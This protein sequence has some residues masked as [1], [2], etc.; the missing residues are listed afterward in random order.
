MKS[1]LSIIATITLFSS[2]ANAQYYEEYFNNTATPRTEQFYDGQFSRLNPTANN[3]PS[4]VATGYYQGAVAGVNAKDRIRVVR[5]D[6]GGTPI[7]NNAYKVLI[8]N[9]EVNSYGYSVAETGGKYVAA[10][11]VKDA[12][13]TAG[14]ADILIMQIN[15]NNGSLAVQPL[16]VDMDKLQD[17]P[18]CIIASA[19][20]N[21]YYICGENFNATGVNP[22]SF[23]LKYDAVANAVVWVR[24][25]DHSTAAASIPSSLYSLCELTTGDIVACGKLQVNAGDTDGLITKVNAAGGAI[26]HQS[27]NKYIY[28]EFRSIKKS[29]GPKGP[30]VLTGN[31]KIN[32][33]DPSSV[34]LL[35]MSATWTI[36]GLTLSTP[37]DTDYSY[38]VAERK[39][40]TGQYEYF[41]SGKTKTTGI[42][43]NYQGSVFKY[44]ATTNALTNYLYGETRD[45]NFYAID[46]FNIGGINDGM[47]LFGQ[48]FKNANFNSWIT[49]AYLNGLTA[50]GC[51][52]VSPTTS[53]VAIDFVTTAKQP[54]TKTTYTQLKI[55]AGA[56]AHQHWFICSGANP[57]GSNA[58]VSNNGGDTKINATNSIEGW[59]VYP[60]P[61]GEN[62]ELNIVF[63]LKQAN[64]V[65]IELYDA[66]GRLLS[67]NS[68]EA[69]NGNNQTT[70]DM[71]SY[72]KGSY[73]LRLISQDVN[74]IHK[75][76]K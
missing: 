69:Y 74:L 27:Y 3:V 53:K 23:I 19:T 42:G 61:M 22:T 7:F 62:G 15:A 44:N 5:T 14:G 6:I 49:K 38:D 25:F 40:T 66:T 35:W 30:F 10:G 54:Q 76:I 64:N 2:V 72:P 63:D 16:K 13:L 67:S 57:V 20:A 34:L 12:N 58:L 36:G 65:H 47:A 48:I 46:I 31:C 18:S 73:F 8:N 56:I 39:N 33:N 45:D 59:S 52:V 29:T 55:E 21:I 26:V 75:V 4:V 60:N 37:Y 32:A 70:L 9:I 17:V 50:P 51:T 41:T 24:R 1:L 71:S 28:E 11:T 68:M 43:A